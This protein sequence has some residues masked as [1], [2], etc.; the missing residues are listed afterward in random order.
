MFLQ[1]FFG[2]DDNLANTIG[3]VRAAC[4]IN[5]ENPA[6][7]PVHDE[8]DY[9]WYFALQ[10]TLSFDQMKAALM[11]GET[12]LGPKPEMVVAWDQERLACLFHENGIYTIWTIDVVFKDKKMIAKPIGVPQGTFKS[13]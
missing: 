2:K 1:I 13:K 12:A 8:G 5:P 3:L 11:N 6:S 7:V 9:G 4:S 10:V